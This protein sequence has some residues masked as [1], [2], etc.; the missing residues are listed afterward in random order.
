MC[1]IS[2]KLWLLLAIVIAF[3][4]SVDIPQNVVI[5]KCNPGL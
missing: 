4:V 5:S 2:S 1:E 3:G